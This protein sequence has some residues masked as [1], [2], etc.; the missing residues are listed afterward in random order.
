MRRALVALALAAILAAGGF[1]LLT[2]PALQRAGLEPVP[3]GPADLDNGRAMFFA[4]GCGSCHATAGQ[5]DTTLLGG[6]HTLNSDFGTFRVPNIS[7]SRDGIGAW[8]P[9][10]F[11][12]AMR[13]GVAPDGQHYYPAF[14][15]TS[16]Q[17]MSAADVR[18]LFAFIATLPPVE[19]RQP[20]HD[21]AFPYSIRRGL[22]LWKL[23]HVDGEVFRTDPSRS[24]Q[25]NRGAYLVEALAHCAECHSPRNR[26]GA[27]PADRRFAGGPN[28]SGE[29]F[30][31][32]I[33]PHPR[34][35]GNWTKADLVEA[36]ESGMTPEG[37]TLG[38]TMA[39]VV[40][41]T[42][43]LPPQD[44]EAIAEYILS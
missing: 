41:N 37:D 23:L 16:Y 12:R 10:Q 29:G 35:I 2:S 4:G 28:P 19:G 17:R 33:T 9:A 3:P 27:I 38:S 42:S 1:W 31:P 34:G 36:L 32:N 6:G 25:W 39:P 18:D 13:G 8:T 7:P 26:F 15:Y 30:V 11:L 5:R 24:P 14:P 21:L 44:R 43:Q 20:G 22:G 40:R